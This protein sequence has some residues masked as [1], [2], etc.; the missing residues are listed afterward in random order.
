MGD[1]KLQFDLDYIEDLFIDYQNYKIDM[2]KNNN[3]G[4]NITIKF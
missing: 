3:T 2:I 1:I 4:S